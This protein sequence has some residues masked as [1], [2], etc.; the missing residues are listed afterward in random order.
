MTIKREEGG[1][2]GRAGAGEGKKNIFAH[3]RN[4]EGQMFESFKTP[5]TGICYSDQWQQGLSGGAH[6]TPWA[7]TPPSY[8]SISPPLHCLHLIATE[9]AL[10]RYSME[11][12]KVLGLTGEKKMCIVMKEREKRKNLGEKIHRETESSN[13]VECESV[14]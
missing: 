3:H 13:S 10:D 9:Q 14:F 7:I 4:S 1:R 11:G 2:G 6:G 8:P 5:E 12:K